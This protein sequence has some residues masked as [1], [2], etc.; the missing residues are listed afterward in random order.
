[1]DTIIIFGAAVRRD[2]G[3][4]ATMRA[5]VAAA[6]ALGRKLDDPFYVPTGGVGRYGPAEAL[7]MRDLLLADGVPAQRI[8]PECRA[9]NTLRSVRNCLHLL[10][11][12]RGTVH[13][14][15]SGYHLARCVLLLRIAGARA[16]ACPP[17]QWRANP[18][19]WLREAAG[20]P[21]DAAVAVWWRLRG[22]FVPGADG[23][24]AV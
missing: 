14:A 20:L 21:V 15:T 2:G 8:R 6:C 11:G 24:E 16:V 1:M 4:S 13:A 5:R 23:H 3:P 18:Y 7:L 10:G 22:R 9:V 12:Y 19:A 17:G